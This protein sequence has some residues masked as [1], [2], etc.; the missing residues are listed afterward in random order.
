VHDA[1]QVCVL[2]GL[3]HLLSNSQHLADGQATTGRALSE[4]VER[5]PIDELSHDVG[6]PL[7]LPDVEHADDVWMVSEAGESPRLTLEPCEGLVV[8][9]RQLEDGDHDITFEAGVRCEVHALLA[10]LAELAPDD[11]TSPGVTRGGYCRTRLSSGRQRSNG[12]V[13]L[14]RFGHNEGLSWL[15]EC[16]ASPLLRDFGTSTSLAI[17]PHPSGWGRRGLHASLRPD[18]NQP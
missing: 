7:L 15:S 18:R 14:I 2:Q 8:E 13:I 4:R 10:T 1:L 12:F 17:M 11:I 5:A 6:V 9:T 3:T 16:P